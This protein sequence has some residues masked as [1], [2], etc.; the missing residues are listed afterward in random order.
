LAGRKPISVSLGK[1]KTY[2][3]KGEKLLNRCSVQPSGSN[4]GVDFTH[5]HAHTA[6]NPR[7]SSS[8][9][10]G[11]GAKWH[12]KARSTKHQ[13]SFQTSNFLICV[14]AK[15]PFPVSRKQKTAKF[16]C[17][18]TRSSFSSFPFRLFFLPGNSPTIA[19]Y[20]WLGRL[21]RGV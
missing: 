1:W 18:C 3:R 10:T 11:Q 19:S 17:I 9:Q 15:R 8:H 12:S 7:S 14:E 6:L 2:P 20:P 21:W 4:I 5:S 13:R 16:L